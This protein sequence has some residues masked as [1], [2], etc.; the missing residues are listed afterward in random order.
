MTP[1]EQK[2]FDQIGDA[3]KEAV[4]G[5]GG[6]YAIWSVNVRAAL[7]AAK[8]VQVFN[9]DWSL[10]EATQESLREH[11]AIAKEVQAQVVTEG[12]NHLPPTPQA[13]RLSD[14]EID[15]EWAEHDKAYAFVSSK[16]SFEAGVKFAETAFCRKN[17][18][19]LGD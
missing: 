2:A 16:W 7:T 10:L 3:L 15:A 1:Q 6:S 11:M 18:I 8:E 14:A 5:M 13:Q 9:P 19:H 12:G 17:G 4:D